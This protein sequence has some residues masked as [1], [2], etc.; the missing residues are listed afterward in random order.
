MRLKR[1]G[2]FFPIAL[3]LL[4]ADCS[5]KRLAEQHLMLGSPEQVIGD[6]L[7]FTLAYN[8]GAAFGLSLGAHSRILFLLIAVA[9]IPFLY[10][11]YRTRRPGDHLQGIAFALVAGGAAGNALDRVI[12]SGGVV[13]FIDVGI[14]SYRFW[15]FNLA[16]AGITVAAVALLCLAVRDEVRSRKR[17]SAAE[18]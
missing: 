3:V 11:L 8:Q 12:S 7:R 2:L 10:W 4:L 5:T 15:T 16:D 14:G 13:D 9:A 6:V 17:S 18:P 1:L